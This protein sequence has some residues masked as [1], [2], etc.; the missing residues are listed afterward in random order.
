REEILCEV[1]AE[2]LGV[3][4]VGV[5]DDFFTLG[6]HSLLAVRL[7]SRVRSVLGVELSLRTLFEEP[8]VAG[9][10]A[11]IDDADRARGALTAQ[12]RPERL[13]LSNAQR[14]LW[15]IGQ[16]EGP[17]ATYNLPMALR[18]KGALD[19][20]ALDAALRDV[21]GRHE[22]LRTVFATAGGEPYQR[23]LDLEDLG[24]ELLVDDATPADVDAAVAEA[25]GHAF[26]LS[27]EV[28]IRAWLFPAGPDEQVLVVVVHHIAGDGWSMGPLARD[29]SV[30]YEARRAGRAP[31]W[32]PLPVQY[33]DYA[34]WQRELLGDDQDP[35]S[36]LSRQVA[37]WR[38]T[39]AGAPEELTLPFDRPRPAVASHRGHTAPLEV[40]AEVHTRLLEVARTEG[41]TTFM[42]LQ[43][44]L[45]VLLSRLGAGADIP[46]GSAH[47]GR[48]DEALDDLVGCFVNT[49]VLRAD[50]SGDP[51]FTDVLARV[52]EAGLSGGA[53]QDVPFERLVEE[54]APVRSMARHPLF[55]IVLTM[56]N[57][58]EA[59]LDLGDVQAAGMSVGVS[60]AKF[61]LDVLVA[62]EF[63][64]E[65]A[66]AGFRGTVTAAA[67]LFD[68]EAAERIAA[69]WAR[70]LEAVVGDPRVRLS[71]VD[72]LAED[73]LHR[74]LVEWNDTAA[75][76]PAG[77]VAVRFEAQVARTPD[78]VAVVADGSE[79]SYAELDARANRLAHYLVGQGVGPESVVGLCLG[80]GVEM[81]AAILAVWK[82]G[83]AYLPID[84]AQPA[85]R[86][87]FML[88]DTRAVLLLSI[89]DILDE[90][91]VGRVRAVAVDE[92][93]VGVQLS[94]EPDTAPQVTTAPDQVAYVIYTSGSTGRPKGVAI[95]HGS[96][97]NYVATVPARVGFGT[98]GDRYA[99]LQAQ[100]TDLGNT[101]AFA[102]L[103]SGGELH[104]LG[105]GAVTDPAAVSRYL[106]EHRIDHLKAVPSHLA[107]LG[108]ADGLAKVLPAK[109]LV[110]GGEAAPSAWVLDLLA[111]AGD[112]AV[113]NHY[114]PTETTI[115]VA[116]M[117][118]TAER[119]ADGVVPVGA[120]VGNT[121]LYVL[122]AALGPVAP[123]VVGELYIAGT[124][125]ARG[126][127]RRPGLTAERFVACPF[128]GTGERMYRTGDRAR[129][130]AD[131]QV[132]YLGRTDE[133]V[134]IRGFRIEPGEVQSALAAHPLVGQAVV[135]AREDVPG[136][137]RLVAYVVA[138]DPEMAQDPGLPA[139]IRKFAAQRLPEHMVPS[140]VVV[141]DGLP[142][143]GNGKLDRKAL[144]APDGAAARVGRGPANAREEILCAAFAEVLGLDR[145]GVDDDFFDLG[146]HSLLAVRLVSRI[147]VV[148]GVELEIRVLFEAPT[149]AGL[150]ACIDEADGARTALMAQERPERV[151]LSFA[152][153]RLW[154]IGELEGPS[155]TYNI[156]ITVRLNGAVDTAA[157]NAALRDVI[158]RHEV[159]RT[160]FATAD[161]EPYQR[162]LD[163]EDLEWGLH[164]AEVPEA[165]LADAIDG[166]TRYAFDL[167]AEVP[168][169]AWL[170]S[171]GP[172]DR[173]VVV[174]IHHIAGDG[175]STR[176]LARDVSVAYE[177]RC[178]GRAPE[179][180]PLPVQYA[181]YALWQR[182]LLG[183]END[184]ESRISRQVAYWREALAGA[185]EELELPF[186]HQRPAVAS[187]QGHLVPLEISAEVHARLAEVTRAEGVTVAMA[188]Q[189]ALAVLLSNLGAGT[190][191]PIGSVN[192][193]RTDEALD[194]LVGFF[195]N[196]LVLRT[197]LSGNPTFRELLSR[198]RE[199]SLS[200]FAHQDVP[201][202]RLV[203]ELAPT[204]SLARHPLFQ[205]TLAVQN[206]AEAVL[207]LSGMRTEGAAE[208]EA[209]GA[210]VAKFDLDVS[211]GETF[212]AQGA[213]AGL[214]GVLI[215]AADLFEPA[216]VERLAGRL[217][218]VL[219]TVANDPD[220]LLSGV[221]VLGQVERRRLLVEWNGTA[222]EVPAATIPELFE[223]QVARTPDAVAVVAD[224]V[225]VSYAE[226]DARANRLA[227]LL[228]GRGVG[229]ESVVGVCLERGIDLVVALLAVS[230][231][232]A[233]Y[234]PVDP[235]YPAERVEFMLVDAGALC[236]MTSEASQGALPQGVARIALDAPSVYGELEALV[237]T[238]LSDADRGGV[239]L[240]AHPAWVIY[241]SGS[242]GRPKG[243]VV[244]HVGV[245]SLVGA[246]AER[247]AVDGASRVLQFASV[248][249]D[250][251]S[252][253]I[254][255]ALCAGARLVV[256]PAEVLVPGAGLVELV[257]R[258]GV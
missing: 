129:W 103:V 32:E 250:A 216:T 101:V 238:P 95:T 239:L 107:A 123:G 178:A 121:R 35:E 83:A 143:T 70:V 60:S 169:R 22:V 120:P 243:V 166:A 132:V 213:P 247:F 21:I 165:G 31:Q 117:H 76:V 240:T 82:A 130:T 162:I 170:F 251:A 258:H 80:R 209:Q 254:W 87:S 249:F 154:F 3:D 30:A 139:T 45:A 212:D 233:A 256:A 10:A 134:K 144:P 44:A 137:R 255:V 127:V 74:V 142:L 102:S 71:A 34:L 72:V 206:N 228:V 42:V 23:V 152:Q 115:G 6:G 126:Y 9:L 133:Q 15:F 68:V 38:E 140:A 125:L 198:V 104:V 242:T 163:I 96:L 114:G 88:A 64:S 136:D 19:A 196:T 99:L 226:L 78:A 128:G 46:I 153:R 215:A 86:I 53:H 148:L 257:A 186:D 244:T 145:V 50:L 57:T 173:V 230:K 94:M 220:R 190:D 191:I 150:A 131:G 138:D 48:T 193:G 135:I 192:A 77:T 73:D 175:W 25:A 181:D 149:V 156:P 205:V 201:F 37:Y 89:E 100:A 218:F 179:W 176:P 227:R 237:D 67:D 225:E 207:D 236:V 208:A 5:D 2:V 158:G 65:G 7:V 141:L 90:L 26:D 214:R 111:A 108:T 189:A 40:P 16:L 235:A 58:I 204:R 12:K 116:T 182:E 43:A 33:A 211:V 229:P 231:A 14:R 248:G 245:G 185:P 118:L 91:P 92:P 177:A 20:G 146:G 84:P 17:S 49:L 56:Q 51:T 109:S 157:L 194:D 253:E 75:E 221:D 151:P 63:D 13:P 171:A 210:T 81:I 167:S 224:G 172:E 105:E 28:P 124:Q 27:S 252:A 79:V 11:R 222:A 197:D 106:A 168:F 241:T 246:Q 174:T 85:E 97:A 36:M 183:D 18:L 54:L 155:P 61:D 203:E 188:L 110:L 232:G 29:V 93:L 1:F 199:S 217:A 161:G 69:A 159:L 119:V 52:R 24:W 112:R 195:V 180:E 219:E 113:F 202:E 147:R 8:T 98:P 4:G 223:A 62:E 59:V 187:Y 39:L 200:A 164:V 41:V 55:Q 234:L 66:P 160:V 47:A 184:P 122:D